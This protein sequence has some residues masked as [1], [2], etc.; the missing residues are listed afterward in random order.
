MLS[1]RCTGHGAQPSR[2]TSATFRADDYFQGLFSTALEEGEVIT[3]VTLPIPQTANYQKFAQPASRF[4][5]VGVFVAKHADGVRVAVTGASEDGVHRWSEG[6]TALNDTF[7][8]D[9]LADLAV[10]SDGLITDLHGDG[11]LSGK[12]RKGAD[13]ARCRVCWV[14][15]VKHGSC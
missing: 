8:A 4:A 14:R 3:S 13:R 2:R 1:S 10:S 15:L 11:F 12:S 7:S 9:A 5:L 6:E